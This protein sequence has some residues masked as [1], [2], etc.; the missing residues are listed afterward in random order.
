MSPARLL[1]ELGMPPEG[2]LVRIA[3]QGAIETIWILTT[4]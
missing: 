4:F 1:V 3:R 2:N